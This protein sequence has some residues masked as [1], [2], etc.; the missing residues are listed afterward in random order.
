MRTLA[1]LMLMALAPLPAQKAGPQRADMA[2]MEMSF[3]SRLQASQPNAPL[4]ILGLTNGVY[5]DGYGAVFTTVV[6]LAQSGIG[7]PFVRIASKEEIER[8]HNSKL[9]TLPALRQT[10]KDALLDMSKSLDRLPPEEHIV[11]GV[12]LFYQKWEDRSAMPS[13]IVMQAKRGALLDVAMNRVP[14]TAVD[15]IVQTREF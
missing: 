14:K 3:D 9:K 6:N 2:A 5:L 12:T 1:T 13:Q 10:M 11:L 4:I 7:T 15:S 8:V